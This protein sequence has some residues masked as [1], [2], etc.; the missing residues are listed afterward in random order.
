MLFQNPG[1][2]ATPIVLFLRLCPLWIRIRS[3]M[4]LIS[5]VPVP[6]LYHAVI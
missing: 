5:M 4:R 6:A 1:A 2:H 3:A